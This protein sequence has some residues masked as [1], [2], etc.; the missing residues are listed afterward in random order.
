[1]FSIARLVRAGQVEPL[2][3]AQAAQRR[4]AIIRHGPVVAEVQFA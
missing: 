1:M 3:V 2:Q 4:H